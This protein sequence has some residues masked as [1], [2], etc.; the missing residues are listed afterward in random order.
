MWEHHIKNTFFFCLKVN[1]YNLFHLKIH[2]LTLIICLI[3]CTH[4]SI[5]LGSIIMS[6]QRLETEVSLCSRLKHRRKYTDKAPDLKTTGM[7]RAGWSW[8]LTMSY[9]HFQESRPW[10]FSFRAFL[11]SERFSEPLEAIWEPVRSYIVTT[12]VTFWENFY[13]SYLWRKMKT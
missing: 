12:L 2:Y 5:K 9:K 3:W 8:S 1:L 10:K 6:W 4:I 7:L 13:F 11:P